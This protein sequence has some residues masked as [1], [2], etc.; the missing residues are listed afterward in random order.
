MPNPSTLGTQPPPPPP[1]PPAPPLQLTE[2][3]NRAMALIAEPQ[4]RTLIARWEA[5]MRVEKALSPNTIKLYM[6]VI[7]EVVDEVGPLE[8]IT[9][10]QIR[11]WLHGRGGLDGTIANRICAL[12]SVYKFMSRSK[13]RVE[14]PMDAID[15]P[16]SR[17]GIPKP[18]KD[19]EAKLLI[20]DEADEIAHKRLAPKNKWK[21]PLGQSRAM[22]TFLLETGLRIHEAVAMDLEVPCPEIMVLVGKGRKEALLPLTE[23]ARKAADFLG[24]KWPIGARGTQRRFEKAG[25]SPHQCRHTLGCT[26]ASSGADLGEIQE[27]LRHE[28][29]AT[30]K[31]YA[32]YDTDRLRAAQARRT[33]PQ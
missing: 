8:T 14:N 10:E 18:I 28:N 12:R 26:L 23:E 30:T 3:A 7:R 31:G 27:L 21:R 5:H 29:P 32:A 24:G 1:P 16:K 17:R 20:L 15:S 25:F 6:R 4:P 33:A 19:V 22:A 11:D 9:T 2:S 13:L